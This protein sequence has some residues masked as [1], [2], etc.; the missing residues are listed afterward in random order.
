MPKRVEPPLVDD[1]LHGGEAH[2]V[3]L[4]RRALELVHL[5]GVE[6]VAGALVPVGRAPSA[7]W[8]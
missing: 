3:Q 5:G 1:V 2:A 7:E 6:R 4:V 8:K